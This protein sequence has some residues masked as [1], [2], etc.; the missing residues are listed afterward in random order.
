MKDGLITYTN[1]EDLISFYA[2]IEVHP[3]PVRIDPVSKRVNPGFLAE[4]QTM[5][6]LI[7]AGKARIVYF[8]NVHWQKN[9]LSTLQ[10]FSEFPDFNPVYLEDGLV[11]TKPE[12]LKEQTEATLQDYVPGRPQTFDCQP[13]SFCRPAVF[14]LRKKLYLVKYYQPQSFSS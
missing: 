9:S 5:K 6:K 13:V 4:L 14:D 2:G 7:R 11:I 3:L 8:K 1:A 12:S 10:L